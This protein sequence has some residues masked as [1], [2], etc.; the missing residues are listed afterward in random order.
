MSD[1]GEIFGVSDKSFQTLHTKKTQRR[2]IEIAAD[3][4]FIHLMFIEHH[5]IN[6]SKKSK[7]RNIEKKR[8]KI[9]PINFFSEMNTYPITKQKKLNS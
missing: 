5:L 6:I 7:H 9:T 3:V 4:I 2:K 1:E 8:E